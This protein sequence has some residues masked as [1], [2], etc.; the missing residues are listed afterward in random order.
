MQGALTFRRDGL[1][2]ARTDGDAGGLGQIAP[3]SPHFNLHVSVALVH[4]VLHLA[5]VKHRSW[6]A[7]DG[8]VNND[9]CL[10]IISNPVCPAHNYTQLRR[11]AR[12][13]VFQIH[14]LV[15]YC[16]YLCVKQPVEDR[17]RHS[18]GHW[19]DLQSISK[20]TKQICYQFGQQP[21]LKVLSSV[22]QV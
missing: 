2:F 19:E 22:H 15:I 11:D 18:G 13:K 17:K 5:K 7:T 21:Q 8:R 1:G 10:F 4:V 12:W 6:R 16:M 3:R 9:W 14:N 20:L